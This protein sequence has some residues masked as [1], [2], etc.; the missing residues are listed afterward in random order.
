[1]RRTVRMFAALAMVIGLATTGC[2]WIGDRVT[3][4]RQEQADDIARQIR[5]M[6]GV[7]K[8]ETNYRKNITEGELFTLRV[9]LDRDAT[10]AQAA[11][12]GRTFVTQADAAGFVTANSAEMVLSYPLPPGENNR[13]SDT[14]QT[15]VDIANRPTDAVLDADQVAAEFADWLQ[16]GQS[17]VAK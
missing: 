3:G 15:S 1:M 4:N 12:V 17:R 13:F 6:P 2:S 7:S 9:L 10:P 5:S 11:E 14:S 8:V 16:A